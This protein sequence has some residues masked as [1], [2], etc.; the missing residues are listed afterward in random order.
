MHCDS[1]KLS[2]VL[3][4]RVRKLSLDGEDWNSDLAPKCENGESSKKVCEPGHTLWLAWVEGTRCILHTCNRL[5]VITAFLVCYEMGNFIYVIL[6]HLLSSI[7]WCKIIDIGCLQQLKT[8]LFLS[9]VV[10]FD[11][12]CHG[13]SD[14]RRSFSFILRRLFSCCAS[15]QCSGIVSRQLKHAVLT[16]VLLTLL[17]CVNY[18]SFHHFVLLLTKYLFINCC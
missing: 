17:R 11:T 10:W 15:T 18:N 2:A 8:Q 1:S 9:T 16:P 13:M 7:H 5:V 14:F 4:F 12:R 3:R 6:W